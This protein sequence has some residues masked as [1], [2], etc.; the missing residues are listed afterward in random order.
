MKNLL[1]RAN[2]SALLN[3][4][5]NWASQYPSSF[6]F[7]LV[8]YLI[9][10]F[11]TFVSYYLE[12]LL[13]HERGYSDSAAGLM[14][15]LVGCGAILNTLLLS[16]TSDR[17]GRK[18]V[19]TITMALAGLLSIALGFAIPVYLVAPLAFLQGAFTNAYGIAMRGHL[20]D[21]MQGERRGRAGQLVYWA[22][23]IGLSLA[24]S[25]I[26]LMALISTS[27]SA[28][29]VADG[30]TTLVYLVVVQLSI[31]RDI[32]RTTSIRRP[33]TNPFAIWK[34]K[35]L[36]CFVLVSALKDIVYVQ[37]QAVL[38]LSMS[39]HGLS[40]WH[41]GLVMGVNAVVVLCLGWLPAPKGWSSH[42]VLALSSLLMGAGLCLPVFLTIGNV[43]QTPVVMAVDGFGLLLMTLGEILSEAGEEGWKAQFSAGKQN[44]AMYEGAARLHL[45][46][47]SALAPT[48]GTTV[49]QFAGEIVLWPLCLIAGAGAAYG[50]LAMEYG[51]LG[52]LLFLW[53]GAWDGIWEIWRGTLSI[54]KIVK[55][56]RLALSFKDVVVL[57]VVLPISSSTIH[58]PAHTLPPTPKGVYQMP[59]GGAIEL[60]LHLASTGNVCF[61]GKG[62]LTVSQ[63]WDVDRIFLVGRLPAWVSYSSPGDSF[64]RVYSQLD[65]QEG[66]NM[67]S[68]IMGGL[69]VVPIN[70]LHIGTEPV[71]HPPFTQGPYAHEVFGDPCTNRDDFSAQVTIPLL[72]KD[73][74]ANAGEIHPVPNQAIAF[75]SGVNQVQYVYLSKDG[76]SYIELDLDRNQ[77][78]N[79]AM[80][81]PG[82]MSVLV[83]DVHI[84]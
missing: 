2:P 40:T 23:N 48:T 58:L 67:V 65:L 77:T 39:D 30:A 49:Y 47:G 78:I 56:K 19:M 76:F 75:A 84:N 59:C 5:R 68:A 25:L 74:F 21:I 53:H 7:I 51:P 9:N 62:D 6:F 28:L 38:P 57:L 45:Y 64:P 12:L 13:T 79:V 3:W 8:G 46:I 26:V 17:L 73:C 24:P 14:V 10:G 60:E 22:H 55:Q 82:A 70:A 71:K 33:S 83:T 66:E 36:G 54:I 20:S 16:W 81:L 15:T 31:P 4:F 27:Y 34:D 29:F 11:G 52:A 1:H 18:T 69:E 41:I 50:Y 43:R 32:N 35:K 61:A 72:G 80:L 44:K 37:Y 42:K 63:Y